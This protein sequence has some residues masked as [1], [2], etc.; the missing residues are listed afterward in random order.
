MILQR[1]K[2]VNIFFSEVTFIKGN[3]VIVFITGG[4]T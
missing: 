4:D 2:K 3:P 1:K